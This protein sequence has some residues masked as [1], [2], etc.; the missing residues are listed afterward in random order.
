M[1]ERHVEWIRGY[2]ERVGGPHAT[3]GRCKYAAEEMAAVFNELRVVRGHVECPEPWG[4][5]G[6]WWCVTADGEV[7]DP[8]AGQFTSGILSYEE[9]VDGA[10]V[11]LGKCMDC[12]EPIW[13]PADRGRQVFC[14]ASCSDSYAAYLNG[15]VL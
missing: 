4:R 11:R 15:G 14:D 5:R 10:P 1:D 3:I 9:Y 2:E 6:H 8:T 7:V 12:G 13:G